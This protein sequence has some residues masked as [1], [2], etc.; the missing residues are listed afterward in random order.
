MLKVDI[1][2]DIF[3]NTPLDIPS[4]INIPA[5]TL[6]GIFNAAFMSVKDNS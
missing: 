5:E 1:I 4:N 3:I 6:P 2:L